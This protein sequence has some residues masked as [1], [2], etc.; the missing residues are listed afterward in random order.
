MTDKVYMPL[1]WEA[2]RDIPLVAALQGLSSEVLG[3]AADL[4]ELAERARRRPKDYP[5]TPEVYLSQAEDL[6]RY[7]WAIRLIWMQ[8]AGEKPEGLGELPELAARFKLTLPPD[9]ALTDQVEGK[10]E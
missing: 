3:H 5:Q 7:G 1:G 4:E 6:R 9:W 8:V 10:A 2:G